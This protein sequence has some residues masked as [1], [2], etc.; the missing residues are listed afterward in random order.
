[1]LLVL[2]HCHIASCFY[3]NAYCSF[4]INHEA[5]ATFLPSLLW[6]CFLAS[7][8]LGAQAV[9]TEQLVSPSPPVGVSVCTYMYIHILVHTQTEIL[10][11]IYSS[12]I[13]P[14]SLTTCCF[15]AV[16]LYEC[17]KLILS[18]NF[19]SKIITL[20]CCTVVFSLWLLQIS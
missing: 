19:L 16:T 8:C 2:L 9:S 3:D 6:L 18:L 14:F 17:I 20:L 11:I 5:L 4:F 12:I 1:M 7:R 15:L 13:C 10:N